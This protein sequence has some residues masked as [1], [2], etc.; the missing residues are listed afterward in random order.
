MDWRDLAVSAYL[1]R[2]PEADE[3]GTWAVDRSGKTVRL[4]L[5]DFLTPR[6]R[7]DEEL[8]RIASEFRELKAKAIVHLYTAEG[9]AETCRKHAALIAR[10][11]GKYGDRIIQRASEAFGCS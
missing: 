11:L 10:I 4:L 7:L 2:L 9:F 5:E 6:E 1:C 8:K 3:P